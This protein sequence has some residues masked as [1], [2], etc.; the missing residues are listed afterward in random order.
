[1]VRLKV[2]EVAEARGV[3]NA[4]DLSGRAGIGYA[5]AYGIWKGEAKMLS[6]ETI[7]RL[8][9]ALKVKPGQLFDFEPE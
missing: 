1:M 4:L 5:S 2:N 3:K 6:L 9:L 8:C 7:N